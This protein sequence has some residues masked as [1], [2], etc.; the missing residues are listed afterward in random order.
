MKD[1]HGFIVVLINSGKEVNDTPTIYR[2]GT[3]VEIIDWEQL[4]DG[5][6]GITIQSKNKVFIKKTRVQ[7]DGL[8]KG[9]I[10]HITES[11]DA[12]G[13]ITNKYRHLKDMLVDLAK[14]PF[15]STSYSDINYRSSAEVS[16]RLSEFLPTSNQFKQEL[17][18]IT[19]AEDRLLKIEHMIDQLQ[20][21]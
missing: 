8:L 17:L 4:D 20:G 9:D 19:N 21:Q 7:H 10:E 1:S 15:L 3:Y 12:S 6:L 16:Y 18:E 2:V 13:K 11:D 14:H 5:L